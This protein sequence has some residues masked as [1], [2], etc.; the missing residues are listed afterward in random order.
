[1]IKFT[2]KHEGKSLHVDAPDRWSEVTVAHFINPHFLSGDSISLLSALSGIERNTL[3]NS[4]EDIAGQ[5]MRM[6]GFLSIDAEGF[7]IKG[8]PKTFRL[9][10][11]ECLVPKDIELER[12]GQKIMLQDAMVKH[13]FIYS[14]IPEAIAIY[15]QPSLNEGVFDDAQLED[16][17]EEVKLLKIVD[18]YPIASFFLSKWK[19]LIK[20]GTLY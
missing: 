17:I 10:G 7:N 4:K 14:A 5:L 16:L 9:R 18:V 8:L 11:V 6:V 20:N 13:K 2:F 19:L 1:M 3:L 12:V 15:L